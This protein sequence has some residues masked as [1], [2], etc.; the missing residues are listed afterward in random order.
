MN[1]VNNIH[2]SFQIPAN[3]HANTPAE[4]R[5]NSRSQ[6][7]MMVLNKQTGAV[8][9]H[10]LANLP[11]LLSPGDLLV[12][13]KSRT[14]PA[15]LR[16]KDQKIE[17]RLARKITDLKWEALIFQN[18]ER[19]DCILLEGGGQLDIVGT[20]SEAPLVVVEFR[21]ISE[22]ILS[23]L[24]KYGAPIRYE[25]IHKP[26]PMQDYQTIFASVPGSVEMP[27]AG[28]AFSWKLI[29]QLKKSGIQIA[30]LELH[31]GISYYGDNQWPNPKNH[32]EAYSI[33]VE[34]IELIKKT[35][36][37]EGKII[38]VGTTVVRA[39]E[40]F[41]LENNPLNGETTT[42]LYINRQH[43]LQIVDGLMTGL[44]EP[45]T[46]HLDLLCAFTE[47]AYIIDAYRH[48]LKQQY[49]WHEFGDLNLIF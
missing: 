43:P 13:N 40:S 32:P 18:D 23:Y 15:L 33:P 4:Y 12:F 36:H 35:K 19:R 48:A 8:S 34:T 3:L 37:H 17:I 38:A 24:Y 11:H 6:V 49:L 5:E 27:S 44:H 31:A 22:P 46:S 16:S 28:R 1:I 25:Y 30:F 29:Q 7:N 14:I 39:L 41:A 20:G 9:D 21:Q 45:D 10:H 42:D 26:W 47:E 2:Q